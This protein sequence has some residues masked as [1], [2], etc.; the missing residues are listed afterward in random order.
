M[1]QIGEQGEKQQNNRGQQP[2][3]SSI[4]E[5]NGKGMWFGIS[6]FAFAGGVA[7]SSSAPSEQE[8]AEEVA[9]SI[10]AGDAESSEQ[11]QRWVTPVLICFVVSI[12][13]S[14]A[15]Y[16]DIMVSPELVSTL[17]DAQLGY[18][19]FGAAFYWYQFCSSWEDDSTRVVK[20]ILAIFF[21][22]F[23]SVFFI[24]LF[25]WPSYRI[26]KWPVFNSFLPKPVKQN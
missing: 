3:N 19:S 26:N 9:V 25:K 13:S 23:F 21:S 1:E 5:H 22:F 18:C 24:S 15:H 14:L 7:V 10:Q 2:K 12:F 4:S 16:H 17:R 11:K 6:F 20:L 8:V